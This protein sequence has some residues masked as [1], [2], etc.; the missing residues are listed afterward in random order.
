MKRWIHASESILKQIE[1]FNKELNS[2]SYG[3][4]DEEGDIEGVPLEEYLANYRLLSP[5]QVE[6]LR[7]GICWDFCQYEDWYFDKYFPQIETKFFYVI[8]DNNNDCPTHTF[9][10]FEHNGKF[11]WFESSWQANQGLHKYDSEEEILDDVI[12]RMCKGT[13]GYPVYYKEYN[14]KEMKTG[15]TIPEYMDAMENELEEYYL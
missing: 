7:G 3:L 9:L 15:M 11:Y 1:E 12:G 8:I 6:E 13:P 14:P 10:T 4:P 2:F 5:E